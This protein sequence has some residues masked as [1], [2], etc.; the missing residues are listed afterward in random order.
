MVF[1]SATFLTW[2]KNIF[3]HRLLAW[4]LSFPHPYPGLSANLQLMSVER[5]V[6]SNR[7]VFSGNVITW[8]TLNLGGTLFANPLMVAKV[9]YK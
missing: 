3:R 7:P 1:L 9:S 8:V 2:I 4:Y 5:F 6:W